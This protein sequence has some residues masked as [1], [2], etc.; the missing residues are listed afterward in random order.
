[1]CVPFVLRF[2]Y[3]PGYNQFRFA[4]SASTDV[5]WG[6][7]RD[8]SGDKKQVMSG[9]KGQE[10]QQSCLAEVTQFKQILG[11]TQLCL[12][13]SEIVWSRV[14]KHQL[15]EVK[16]TQ[17]IAISYLFPIQQEA[18]MLSDVTEQ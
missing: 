1:M 2:I 13:S 6:D 15:A 16:H 5:S 4:A 3:L 14:P 12:L 7:F 11:C 17:E 9:G 18:H 10:G 8:C